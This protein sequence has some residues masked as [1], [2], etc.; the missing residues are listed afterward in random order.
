M[1]FNADCIEPGRRVSASLRKII[2]V[3]KLTTLLM[4]VALLSASAAGYSQ[5]T[6]KEKNVPLEKVL[7][8]IEKQTKYVFLY[9]AGDIQAASVT[10]DVSNVSL[11]EALRQCLAGLNIE[12]TVE[13]N[14]VLL[15][16]NTKAMVP[17]SKQK[18]TDL[19]NVHGRVL[20]ENGQPLPGATIQTKDKSQITITDI[21]G[22]FN[23][24]GLNTDAVL[25]IT[26]VGYDKKEVPVAS[27]MGDIHLTPANSK[28]D[29][30][31][32]I[33]YGTTSQRLSTGDVS[34]LKANAIEQ[35]PVENPLLALDGRLPGVYINQTT[36]MQ[37]SASVTQVYIRGRNSIA[38]GTS[39][40]FIIDGVPYSSQTLY[41]GVLEGNS[42]DPLSF[43]N[44]SDIESIDVLKDADA[45]AIYGS[46]GAN[47][48]IMITTKKGHE[49]NTQ[50]SLNAQSGFGQVPHFMDLLNTQQYLEMRHEALS[51]D[52]V[53]P[54]QSADY[55]LLLWDTTRNTNWQRTLLGDKSQYSTVQGTLSGGNP[56]M[57]FNVSAMYHLETSVFPGNT[58]D[59]KG[60]VHLN[61]IN[62]SPN[63]KFNFTFSGNYVL[64]DN[65]LP[66]NDLTTLALTLPP[67]APPIYNLNGTLNWAPNGQGNGTWP[68]DTNPLEYTLSSSEITTNNLI[69]NSTI[70]YQL[71]PSLQLKGNFGY[72]N[73][74][75]DGFHG[76]PFS[77]L[78]PAVWPVRQRYSDFGTTNIHSW[79]VEP[80]INYTKAIVKG[81]LS[82][83]IGATAEQN[84][85]TGRVLTAQG[86]NSDLLLQNIMAA[87]TITPNSDINDI[88]R[89]NAIFGR[90]NYNWEDKYLF[91][92]TTR[93]DG[94]SRYGPED[95]FANFYSI[96]GAWIF[97]EEG[98]FKNH[99]SF[100]SYGKLR[101]SYGTTGN[102]QIGDYTYLDLYNSIPNVG[103][104]YQGAPGIA[105]TTLYTP[106]LQW[107]I[108]RKLEAAI[109]LGFFRNRITIDVNYYRNR[110]TNLLLGYPLPT[111]TGFITVERNVPALV[112][113]QGWEVE[114]NTVNIKDKHFQWHS[115]FNLSVNRNNLLS[116]S[117]AGVSQY[118]S[119]FVGHAFPSIPVYHFLYVDP[120]TGVNTFQSSDGSATTTPNP[121]TDKTEYI[122]I[123]PKYFGGLSNSFTYKNFSLEFTFQFVNKQE[124]LYLYSFIPGSF[125]INQ[126]I[127]VLNR[128][129][130]PGDVSDIERFS[131]N[132]SLL[133]SYTNAAQ[134]DLVYGNASFIRLKNAA[135]SWNIP[136]CI[137]KKLSI[138]SGRLFCQGQNL[139]TF[140]KYQGLDPESGSSALPPLRVIT[141]GTD[142]IF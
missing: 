113:N 118:Y 6:L 13:E 12:Y 84:T 135:F 22:I 131:E 41:S 117:G 50:F 65:K 102:D 14:N 142:L 119:Q 76:V 30:V 40:L 136:A 115:S 29:E 23:L 88:Y 48:V 120:I 123:D 51:N 86:F 34:S 130:K 121:A 125:G 27:D 15:K 20:D 69:A 1:Y 77:A 35:Q 21:R 64:D 74:Q 32:V 17:A 95:R 11:E 99:L 59:R 90:I 10:V 31:K 105:P 25:I 128:W 2:L 140:T 107:E 38:S 92:I 7:S 72:T 53:Q 44:P 55:D 24:K 39:P 4:T 87:T 103:V 8:D 19:I 126:P 97:S 132:T 58:N 114:F 78:D 47:G 52:G 62:T 49:G 36:G 138:K 101:T 45:T 116:I 54:S 75:S 112:Q 46:R 9:D 111:I 134:S 43:I 129:Q 18:K 67:D 85:S 56:D 122:P 5:I 37:G 81:I 79:I 139:L 80:Q 82:V 91:D 124:P 66:G 70:S 61:L 96:A 127:D 104:P 71:F 57:Q 137:L 94:S 109:E 16:S 133:S 108:T 3:M 89:Y 110:S 28:L 33:A 73:M 93:S 63:K 106:N 83:L 100:I 42:G 98:F 68:N 141:F 60:S 26:M